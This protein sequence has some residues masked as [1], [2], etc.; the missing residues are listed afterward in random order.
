MQFMYFF[1]KILFQKI[2]ICISVQ[3]PKISNKIKKI[4]EI[5]AFLNLAFEV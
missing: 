4:R 5:F 3:M 2:R 1:L